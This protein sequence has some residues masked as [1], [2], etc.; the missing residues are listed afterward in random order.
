MHAFNANDSMFLLDDVVVLGVSVCVCVW[1]AKASD[2]VLLP[3]TEN[4]TTIEMKYWHVDCGERASSAPFA[5]ARNRKV[6]AVSREPRISP[7]K[8]WNTNEMEWKQKMCVS[9]L[10][11]LS[12]FCFFRSF[13]SFLR[14]WWSLSTRSEPGRENYMHACNRIVGFWRTNACWD[15]MRTIAHAGAGVGEHFTVTSRTRREE[16]FRFLVIF[17]FSLFCYYSR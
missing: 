15:V 4:H 1:A 2:C 11:K 14:R 10:R 5:C 16:L 17:I 12:T 13:A 9:E 3:H 8:S 6:A 7:L